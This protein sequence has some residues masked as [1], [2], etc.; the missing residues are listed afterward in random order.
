MAILA[1][2]LLAATATKGQ[3]PEVLTEQEYR[4]QF[5]LPADLTPYGEKLLHEAVMGVEPG[6]RLSI[7]RAT[8]RMKVLA[9]RPLA[10]APIVEA[11]ASTGVVIVPRPVRDTVEPVGPHSD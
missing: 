9:Y 11:A 4:L 2:A 5:T 10:S 3:A 6:M 1:F 7:D 8:L